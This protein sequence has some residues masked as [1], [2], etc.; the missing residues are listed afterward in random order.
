MKHI[1][2]FISALLVAISSMAQER[3]VAEYDQR[4]ELVSIVSRLSGAPEYGQCYFASY[5]AEV[6]QFFAPVK[7]HPAVKQLVAMSSHIGYDANM[8]FALR[9][10]DD[11]SHNDLVVDDDYYYQR[12]NRDEE[13]QFLKALADF[14][15]ESHFVE[16]FAAHQPFYDKV[17]A[18]MQANLDAI[19]LSW[20][21]AMFE[22]R[23]EAVRHVFCS[24]LNGPSN[25]SNTYRTAG[26]NTHICIVMGCCFP[27]QAGNP[28][29]Q[30]SSLIPIIVHEFCHSYC[31]PLNEK[32]IS[33]MGDVPQKVFDKNF[34]LLRGQAYTTPLIMMNET[35]V[36]ASVI[37]YMEQHFP[38]YSA[39]EPLLAEEELGFL[40]TG[41]ILDALRQRD[42]AKYPSM[43]SYMPEIVNAVNAFD[44]KQ[45]LRDVKAADRLKAHVKKCTLPS[46]SGEGVIVVKF[47]KPMADHLA[48][49]S[50]NTGA[51]FPTLSDRRPYYEWSKDQKTLTLYVRLA[52]G[53]YAF[54]VYKG[55]VTAAGN[56]LSKVMFYDFEVK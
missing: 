16:F 36:R 22:P 21:D 1:L 34:Q 50:G 25:Y 26:G 18:A 54:S 49:Y 15:R 9:L 17:K 13:K 24:I 33:Q 28:A 30:S 29:Y 51:P 53:R 32:Y 2:I 47:D 56:P 43:E 48:L 23:P 7:D 27:G 20:Y 40:L 14:A 38:G 11:F 37:R 31:N 35:F 8:A 19:D 12:W 55:F 6:D 10:N 45:Y 39:A 52:P 42:M 46:K 5:A 44:L 3:L 4:T 41:T